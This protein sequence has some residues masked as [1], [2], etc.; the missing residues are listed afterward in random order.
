M[1]KLGSAMDL[2]LENLLRAANE[3]PQLDTL[4]ESIIRKRPR[5][6]E[7]GAITK[8]ELAEECKQA[9]AEV[10]GRRRTPNHGR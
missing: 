10:T 3:Q 5:G 6:Q 2:H 1:T 8:E 7:A 4:R 9:F